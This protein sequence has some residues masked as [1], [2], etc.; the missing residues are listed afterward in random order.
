MR[1]STR[2]CRCFS[3]V[4]VAV[5]LGC[6]AGCVLPPETSETG[7]PVGALLPFTGDIAAAGTNIERA[8]RLALEEVNGAGRVGGERLRLISR[9]T[10][11]DTRR[12]LEA[13]RDLLNEPGLRVILG[14]E[15]EDLASNLIGL[16]SARQVLQI[17]GGVTSPTFRNVQDGGFFFRTC[18][19]ASLYGRALADRMRQDGVTS[20]AVLYVNSEYGSGFAAVLSSELALRSI[21]VSALV[22]FDPQQANYS[23]V[24]QTLLTAHP[25]GLVLVAYP[26][27]GAA[28][29]QEWAV[30]GG[31]GRWYLTPALK[32]EGFVVNVPPGALDGAVGVAPALATDAA[33]FAAKFGER[34]AG[35]YPLDAA[36]FYYDAAALS[37]LALARVARGGQTP[38][39]ATLPGALQ[40]V[41]SPPGEP[42][43]WSDLA[44]GLEMIQRGVD[45]DYQ[46]VTGSMD[47]DEQGDV[48][49][50][51]ARFWTIEDDRIREEP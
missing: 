46:G 16:I 48:L 42:V 39:N 36:Y 9:D 49:A 51:E 12:G 31:R 5:A 47:F 30:R 35:D 10:H 17:S 18:P 6:L 27:T 7:L 32:S 8:A 33:S 38:D 13:A 4:F 28:I 34:W 19:S 20:A 14:P 22:S 43:A 40:E 25:E 29:V 3:M 23:K 44:R 41:S 2:V 21:E 24:L 1:P 45:I 11:S 26:G 50:Q 37:A 15:D